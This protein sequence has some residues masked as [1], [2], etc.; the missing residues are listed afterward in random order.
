MGS[1]NKNSSASALPRIK[2]KSPLSGLPPQCPGRIRCHLEVTVGPVEWN[3]LHSLNQS[4]DKMSLSLIWW[5]DESSTDL[6][7]STTRETFTYFKP[8]WQNRYSKVSRVSNIYKIV[9]WNHKWHPFIKWRRLVGETSGRLWQFFICLR[10]I[11]LYC[12]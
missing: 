9:D 12:Q 2:V 4:D 3:P 6:P 7:I 8:E 11:R 1:Y 10:R 5:G